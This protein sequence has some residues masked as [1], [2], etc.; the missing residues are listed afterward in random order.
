MADALVAVGSQPPELVNGNLT[1]LE[2]GERL[3]E[4]I[5]LFRAPAFET[6]L[7]TLFQALPAPFV[8][9]LFGPFWY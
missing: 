4:A 9:E 5:A 6:P 1:P 3:A 7:K 2:A 8:F